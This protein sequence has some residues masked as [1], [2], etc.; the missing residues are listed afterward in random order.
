MNLNIEIDCP[1]GYTRPQHYFDNIAKRLQQSSDE[2]VCNVGKRIEGL[3]PIS[4]KFGSWNWII[5]F[6]SENE[7]NTFTKVQQIFNSELTKLYNSG[8]IRYASW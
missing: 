6:D 5:N 3:S 8:A 7:K 4:A 1:P 2:C